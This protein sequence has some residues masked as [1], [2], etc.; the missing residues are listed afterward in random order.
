M[1]AAPQDIV[2]SGWP[3]LLDM[4]SPAVGQLA[5]FKR[6]SQDSQS[7]RDILVKCS[8]DFHRVH[9]LLPWGLPEFQNYLVAIHA[10]SRVARV[11]FTLCSASR[12]IVAKHEC[13]GVDSSTSTLAFPKTFDD[14]QRDMY[15]TLKA[16][17]S[18]LPAF[19]VTRRPLCSVPIYAFSA[20]SESLYRTIL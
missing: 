10:N 17:S 20:I 9:V 11:Q 12:F 1:R 13:L 2:A 16:T 5:A 6:S 7:V 8:L 19:W 18:T 15:T 14:L 4:K 3:W